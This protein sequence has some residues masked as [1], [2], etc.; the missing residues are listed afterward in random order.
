MKPI[1]AT[2]EPLEHFGYVNND[3]PV[4][5]KIGASI[6]NLPCNFVDGYSSE[7]LILSE[8]YINNSRIE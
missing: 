1:V 7:F 6:I 5:E 3:S 8:E 2:H 4:A